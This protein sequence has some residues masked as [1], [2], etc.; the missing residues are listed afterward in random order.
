MECN[1]VM[2]NIQLVWKAF[3]SHTGS[4]LR[5]LLSEN[6]FTDVTLVS[7]DAKQMKAHKFVLSYRTIHTHIQSRTLAHMRVFH[8]PTAV[9]IQ[10]LFPSNWWF[11][12]TGV[13]IQLVFPSNWCFHPTGVSIQLLFPSNWCFQEIRKDMEQKLK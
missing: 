1:H 3:N 11:H 8:H 12:P 10:L 2:S 4:S 13:S 7:D 6:D 9:S 5:L